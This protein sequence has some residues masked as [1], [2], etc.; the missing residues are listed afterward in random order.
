MRGSTSEANTT[1]VYSPRQ[2]LLGNVAC[3]AKQFVANMCFPARGGRDPMSFSTRRIMA[4]VLL[5]PTLQLSNPIRLLISVE[6]SDFARL[7]LRWLMRIHNVLLVSNMG[8]TNQR[9]E[10]WR[11]NLLRFSLPLR[12][13]LHLARLSVRTCGQ[14]QIV[15]GLFERNSQVA[16]YPNK[17]FSPLVLWRWLSVI[18]LFEKLNKFLFCHK[19]IPRK[20]RNKILLKDTLVVARGN[21]SLI[22]RLSSAPACNR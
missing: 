21:P 6:T 9:Q 4:D 13:P 11:L 17:K 15:A 3:Q 16:R 12:R 1:K 2:P 8:R 18:S 7:S 20:A 14:P 22:S 5:M 10:E 19:N